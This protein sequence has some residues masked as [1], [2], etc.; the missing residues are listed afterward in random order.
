MPLDPE[1]R[2]YLD[3]VASLGLPP[4]QTVTP[5]ENRLARARDPG[6]ATGDV[7]APAA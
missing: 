2:A 1:A 3:R 4:V 6:V 5:Q 7:R